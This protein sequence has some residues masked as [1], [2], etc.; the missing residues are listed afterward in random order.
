MTTDSQKLGGIA[1]GQYVRTDD[2]RLVGGGPPAPGSPNYIQNGTTP[3]TAS[4]SVSGD[5][6][7]GGTLSGKIVSAGQQFNIGGNAVLRA[8]SHLTS[9][10]IGSG[11]TPSGVLS[12]SFFGVN[13]G[14]KTTG[15]ANSFFGA[16]AGKDNT[17]GRSN[18][19]FGS[20]AG[21]ANLDGQ[22]NSFYGTSAGVVN[23]SGENNSFFGGFAGG[24]NISS[25]NSFFGYRAGATS[26]SG[27]GNSFFGLSAGS[28]V[29]TGA[30][31]TF[32]GSGTGNAITT[33]G[34][35]TFIGVL[36]D[37]ASGVHGSTA[38]GANAT[39]TASNS[40]ILGAAGV[41]VGIGTTAP[42]FRLQVD[43]GSIA[44]TTGGKGLILKSPNGQ[45]CRAIVLSDQGAIVTA[46]LPCP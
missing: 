15:P 27:E 26:R 8:T 32:I 37:G 28:K 2:P 5:G 6:T 34:G 36:A 17:T 7:A 23:V 31:N 38:I 45:I 25:G 3:Q 44:I 12:N 13:A 30:E 33:E 14:Q 4:F 41:N 18:S 19:F 39:V 20:G 1:A 24:R 22:N 16:S 10:G 46:S 21:A 11:V 40:V 43:G 35:N 42:K 29:T 9:V